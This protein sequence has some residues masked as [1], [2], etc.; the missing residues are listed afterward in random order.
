ME[1]E[2]IELPSAIA[3]ARL[4]ILTGCRLGEIIRLKGE[5]VDFDSRTLRLSRD[6]PADVAAKTRD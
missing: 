1:E 3:A 5:Y 6:T 2:G 4:L